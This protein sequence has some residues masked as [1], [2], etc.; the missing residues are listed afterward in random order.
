MRGKLPLIVG[1]SSFN[2]PD[3]ALHHFDLKFDQRFSF[4]GSAD[5]SP[6]QRIVN[7]PVCLTEEML[8]V[9]AENPIVLV[10]QINRNVTAGIFV[11][12]NLAIKSR[13]ETVPL[14][15]V[16]DKLELDGLPLAQRPRFGDRNFLHESFY[17]G[18]Y[19]GKAN[20]P[21]KDGRLW[22]MVVLCKRFNSWLMARRANLLSRK[23]RTQ[24]RRIRKS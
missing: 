7:R 16:G 22:A 6:A 4:A 20:S 1:P 19:W 15:P 24:C 8:S 5:A 12:H 23:L 9:P 17:D 13:D 2:Q 11:G 18:S 14:F 10:I 3:H 21:W